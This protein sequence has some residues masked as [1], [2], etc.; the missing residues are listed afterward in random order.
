[1]SQPAA[2]KTMPTA[3]ED[4]PLPSPVL[5]ITSPRRLSLDFINYSII[6]LSSHPIVAQAFSY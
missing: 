4:L 5:T 3:L 1:M 2:R 6:W